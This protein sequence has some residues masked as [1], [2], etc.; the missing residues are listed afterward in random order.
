MKRAMALSAFGSALM[1][2]VSSLAADQHPIIGTY[3][4]DFFRGPVTLQITGVKENGVLEG[5][6][7]FQTVT[8]ELGPA[9]N[10]AQLGTR[11]SGEQLELK[12]SGGATYNLTVSPSALSGRMTSSH[13]PQ[14]VTFKRQ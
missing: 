11:L 10:A 9:P 14:D 6:Y 7:R 5:S 8:Y 13:G 4:W 3:V 2:A 12:T 1:L